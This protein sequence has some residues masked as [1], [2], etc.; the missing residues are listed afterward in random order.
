MAISWDFAHVYP[1]TDVDTPPGTLTIDGAGSGVGGTLRV[2]EDPIEVGDVFTIV[3]STTAWTVVGFSGGGIV[4]FAPGFGNRLFT[5]DTS[6]STGDEV[7]FD[8]DPLPVCFLAGTAIATPSGAVPVER[9][10]IGDTVLT[11]GGACRRVRWIG[12][13]TCH[14][15]FGDPLRVLPVRIAAGALGA[16]VPHR[17]LRLSPDH[18]LLVDGVLVQAGALVNGT[19]VT[20]L[21]AADVGDRF[22]YFH[23]ELEDHSLILAEGVPAETFV[24]NVTRRRFDNHAEYRAL[25][26]EGAGSIAEMAVPRVKSARQLPRSIRQRLHDDARTAATRGPSAA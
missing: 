1:V 24:D 19:T 9:L 16:G 26:G 18:A 11:A 12:R 7:P 25:V 13:Q 22:V 20:R 15:R 21:G 10:A 3:G 17:D 4:G 23:V 8:T 2:P 5:N 6:L 14:A